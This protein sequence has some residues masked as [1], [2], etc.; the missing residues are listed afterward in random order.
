MS[1]FRKSIDQQLQSVIGDGDISALPGAGSPLALDDDSYT[2]ADMRAANKIMRD[3]D[4]MPAWVQHGKALDEREE[5]LRQE[6]KALAKRYLA[7]KRAARSS[8]SASYA[9]A[10][11]QRAQSAWLKRLGK[12]N[13]DCLT[14]NLNAPRGMPHRLS[15]R[16][17]ALIRSA[18]KQ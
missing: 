13:Q 6:I 15:L 12:Y 17:E 5:A 2:P 3:H 1:R 11:W 8:G 7:R 9:E 18:L 4:V 14:H 16:G 10:E